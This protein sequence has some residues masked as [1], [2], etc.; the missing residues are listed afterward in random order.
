MS[1][2]SRSRHCWLALGDSPRSQR[3]Q[4]LCKPNNPDSQSRVYIFHWHFSFLSASVI[5]EGKGTTKTQRC[6]WN[7]QVLKLNLHSPTHPSGSQAK[8][9][10]ALASSCV[11]HQVRTTRPRRDAFQVTPAGNQPV[12]HQL[13]TSRYMLWTVLLSNSSFLSF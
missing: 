2:I 4:D 10:V 7:A 6:W 5:W 13:L 9:L 8:S 3:D 11:T 12:W 1:S